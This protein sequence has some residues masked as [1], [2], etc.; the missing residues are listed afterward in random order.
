[1]ELSLLLLEKIL[2]MALMVLMGFGLVKLGTAKASSSSLLSALTLYI[3]C[4]CMILSAFQVEWSSE[5]LWGLLLALAAAVILHILYIAL[6]RLLGDKLHLDGVERASLIYSNG[7]NL[8]VPLVSSVL[9][10]EYVFYCCAFIAFQ[11]ILIWVHLPGLLS[12][13]GERQKLN[14]KKLL[15]NPN[16]LA[17]AAGILCFLLRITFPPIIGGTISAVSDTIGPVAM[18]MIGMLM[19]D[20]DLPATFRRVKYWGISL[21]RLVVYPVLF[22]LLIALSHV[23]SLLPGAK[24]ILVVTVLAASAPVA[25]SVAQMVDIG[26]G[27]AKK[28]GAINVMSVILCIVTM[29]LIIALY[30]AIC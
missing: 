2:S 15:L 21:G 4:P 20:T 13:K 30:E 19:A 29:P 25:V 9:G 3:I 23:T 17:I 10:E 8:I 18:F 24:E 12:G 5:R 7:G 27:D 14:L 16:I 6:T 26:G 1:M 28:A 22:V 11:T